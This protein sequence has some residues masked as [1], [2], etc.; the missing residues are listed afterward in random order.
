MALSHTNKTI[1]EH[2]RSDYSH[3]HVV[4]FNET[5]GEVILKYT[6]QG[7]HAKSSWNLV[8]AKKVRGI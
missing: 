5:D 2:I 8:R 3:Y 6:A 7:I 4:S 1:K